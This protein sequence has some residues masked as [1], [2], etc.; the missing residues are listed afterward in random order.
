MNANGRVNETD[1]KQMIPDNPNAGKGALIFI[2]TFMV[3]IIITFIAFAL[4]ADVDALFNGGW[5]ILEIGI[6][7]FPVGDNYPLNTLT[8][9]VTNHQ[10]GQRTCPDEKRCFSF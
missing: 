6:Y 4:F 2:S 7:V 5:G 1:T 3:G 9:K 10:S 8:D